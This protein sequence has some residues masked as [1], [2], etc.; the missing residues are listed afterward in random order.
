MYLL[1][2]FRW[3]GRQ[4]HGLDTDERDTWSYLHTPRQT[5][6]QGGEGNTTST[7]CLTALAFTRDQLSHLRGIRRGGR[8]DREATSI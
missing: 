6:S 4:C 5:R 8:N 3:K 1:L 2:P 7:C